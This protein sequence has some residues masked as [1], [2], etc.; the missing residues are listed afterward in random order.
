MISSTRSTVVLA[1][2]VA[3]GGAGALVCGAS[4]ATAGVTCD[5]VTTACNTAGKDEFAPTGVLAAIDKSIKTKDPNDAF[6]AAAIPTADFVSGCVHAKLKAKANKLKA[7]STLPA[8]D[9][10]DMGN[11]RRPSNLNSYVTK[12]EVPNS[13]PQIAMD[14]LNSNPETAGLVRQFASPAD[15][16]RGLEKGAKYDFVRLPDGTVNAISHADAAKAVN[17]L[18]S[19]LPVG[20]TSLV[21]EGAGGVLAAGE[22]HLNPKG[23]IENI[24]TQSG[25]FRVPLKNMKSQMG[26][27]MPKSK[28]TFESPS[29]TK[30]FGDS[31]P[32]HNL[33]N[34]NQVMEAGVS[35]AKVSPRQNE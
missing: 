32:K 23:I 3:T 25:H 24:N 27:V 22:I 30:L 5:V 7:E 34:C 21:P 13:T 10:A 29:F 20:H 6:N 28:L 18:K 12:Q 16:M 14:V 35:L 19:D 33:P 1:A 2:T 15:A 8:N 17:I 4:A 26:K 31:T 11:G 9:L